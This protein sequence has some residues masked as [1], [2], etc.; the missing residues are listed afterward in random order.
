MN[1]GGFIFT[2][3][4]LGSGIYLLAAGY[5]KIDIWKRYTKEE[6]KELFAKHG[7]TLKTS[8]LLVTIAGILMLI[9]RLLDQ[10]A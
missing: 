10:L 5:G 2:A 7:K 9:V 4:V 8:G 6:K 1:I 3:L